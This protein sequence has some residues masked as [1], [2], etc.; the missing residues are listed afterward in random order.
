MLAFMRHEADILVA[1]TIIE[2]GLDIPLCNTILINRAD[3]HGLS[4]LYQLRG[5][6]GRS[7]RRSYAYLLVPPDREL[8]DLARRRLAALK[9]FS[10]LG[11]GFKIAA[12]DLELRGAGNLLGGQQSGHI[13]AVGL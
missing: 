12:L 8:N 3:R 10:D 1:T 4:E 2:N 13:E 11:A 5:R 7:N 9:E 6:V